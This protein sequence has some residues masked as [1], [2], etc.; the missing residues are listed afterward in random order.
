MPFLFDTDAISEVLRPRPC[1]GYL[2]WLTQVSR[3]HQFTSAVVI[4]ELYRGAY[5]SPARDRHLSNIET[6]LLPVITVLPFDAAV[7]RVYGQLRAQLEEAGLPLAEADLQIAATACY[8]ALDL[9]TGNT[10]HF[11][12]VPGLRLCRMLEQ[13][14]NEG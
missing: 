7:A 5:R 1:P 11:E 4:G 14:R 10:R 2:R 9:V 12:R 6:R 13:A 3:E 8:H